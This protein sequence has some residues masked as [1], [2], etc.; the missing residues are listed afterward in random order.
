MVRS[1][2]IPHDLDMMPQV[3]ELAG[4]QDFQ[5]VAGGWIEPIELDDIGVTLYVSGEAQRNPSP[6][7]PRATALHWF[8]GDGNHRSLLIGDAILVGEDVPGGPANMARLIHGVL[9][10]HEFVVQISPT[11]AEWFDTPA[12]FSSLFDTAVWAMLMDDIVVRGVQL[13]IEALDSCI[14]DEADGSR[15]W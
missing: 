2:V 4:L 8:F 3:R 6:F 7:N 14:D 15:L 5:G 1:I 11:G 9:A 10:H 13:R 12:R